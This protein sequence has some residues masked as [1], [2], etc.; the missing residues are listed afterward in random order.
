M[1]PCLGGSCRIENNRRHRVG[2]QIWVIGDRMNEFVPRPLIAERPRMI[3]RV[4]LLGVLLC[5]AASTGFAWQAKTDPVDFNRDIKPLLSDRCFSCHGP[6]ETARVTDVRFDKR[7]SVLETESGSGLAVIHA[8][9]PDRSELIQRIESADPDQKMPPPDAQT[10]LS[11]DEIKLLRRW[12]AEGAVWQDQWSFVRPVKS[13]LPKVKRSDWPIVP[14]DWFIL[15]QLEK[16]DVE[17]ATEAPR[18]R[19]A[20]RLYFDLTG[21][22]P[23]LAQLDAFLSDES[24][25]AYESLVDQL[26]ASEHYGERMAVD[27]L[28]VARYSDTYGFQVDR[29]RFVW[30][31]RDWVIRAFNDNLSFDQFLT[32]QLAGDLLPNATDEQTL[33]TTFSRLHPQKVEGGSVPEEFRVEYVADRN[34]T[35]GTAFLGLT[36]ECCRCHDHKFDPLLQREYYQFFAFFNNIDESG[37]YSYFTSSVPTPT[38]LLADDQKKSAVVTAKQQALE[39]EQ[40]LADIAKDREAAFTTWLETRPADPA[41]GSELIPN[42]VAYLDFENIKG[43]ANIG[44]DGRIGQAVQ[45]S[46]DDGIGLKIGN[47]PRQQPFSVA[48]WMKT[49]DVKER[50]VVFHRSRAWTDAGSRGYQLLIEDG[51][52]SAALIHFWPGNAI[53]V[54]TVARIPTNQWLHVTVTYDGSS[55]ADGLR[56]YVA[57]KPAASDVV[58]DHLYKNITGGGG[59]NITIGQRFRDRGFTGGQ[60]DEFQVF[61]RELTRLE[62]KQLEDG[63]TLTEALATMPDQLTVHQRDGL[64]EFYLATVDV[65]QREQMTALQTARQASHALVDPL[66]EI[67]VMRDL[68]SRRPTYIL[69]RGA[70]D[71]PGEAVE[72]NTPISLPS[73]PE[74][75]PRNRLG[76]ARWL[77][78]PD[79]PL[80]ARVAVNRY[81]QMCF[82]HGIVGTPDDFGSQGQPPTHPQLLDWLAVDFVEHGWD[83]KRL[84]KMMVMSATYRQNS[85][86]P[87]ELRKKD[88]ENRLF[89]RASAF[90]L[91]AE[92]IRDNYLAASGLMVHKVGGPPVRPYEVAVSFKPVKHDQGDGLYRRSL[93]TFWKRTAPAP[94]MMSLDAAKRDVCSVRRERT[95]SPLQALVLM[96]APQFVEAARVMSQRLL[97]KHGADTDALIDEMFRLLTSRLPE[98]NERNILKQLYATQLEHFKKHPEL[99][100][101]LLKTGQ[102]PADPSLSAAEVATVGILVNAL[103]NYDECVTRR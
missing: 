81:W 35:F 8:G 79:H 27:W 15:R 68:D 30:P 71:A 33:A 70:Y 39:A 36:L 55:R 12:V 28:D 62:I 75:Q 83:V 92:M 47:F 46:G 13:S 64:R 49:P 101:D 37:L 11:D 63:H 65:S 19:L 67:M 51:R 10:S 73:F 16:A 56:I 3:L 102:A 45:L 14:F 54:R 58:R 80:T 17:P 22:P 60:V 91:P 89:G 69:Q 32:W 88:P 4:I 48:L 41:K 77:T 53:C 31:W 5:S 21:L 61:D 98:D 85:E 34:H 29:D 43:G 20:R 38:L 87:A 97:R 93:Y 24:P 57:G 99:S 7:Q 42:R 2:Q 18:H 44:V 26:L 78:R 6:D 9:Q 94:V 23:T 100:T 52:L 95:S 25:D 1:P 74:N 40:A 82:G 59:N 76:L 90:R 66:Q 72:P 103:M 84:L 50:A 86:L 96:N